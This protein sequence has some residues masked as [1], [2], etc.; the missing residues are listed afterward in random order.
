M[1]NEIPKES[2]TFLELMKMIAEKNDVKFSIDG[3]K[4][5]R[6]DIKV[7][8]LRENGL[9]VEYYFDNLNERASSIQMKVNSFYYHTAFYHDSGV[10]RSLIEADKQITTHFDEDGAAHKKYNRVKNKDGSMVLEEI[11]EF[12]HED[13]FKIIN[14]SRGMGFDKG[15]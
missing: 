2:P 14:S 4:N 11:R 13:L 5:G 6:D 12:N 3:E 1:I 10:I 8:I 9:P 15:L 7:N